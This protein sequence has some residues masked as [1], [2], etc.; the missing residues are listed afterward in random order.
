MQTTNGQPL[1]ID[2]DENGSVTATCNAARLDLRSGYNEDWLQTLLFKEP[3]LLSVGMVDQRVQKELIPLAMEVGLPSGICD[4]LFVSRDGYIAVVETKLWR[5]PQ[6][7]REVVAQT[8]DYATHIRR[9]D[10]PTL[11]SLWRERN[12]EAGTSL[13]QHVE[14]AET[15]AEW[16]DLVSRNLKAGRM[17]LV[18]AGDGIR[19]EAWDL[20]E[21]VSG[22]PDFEFRLG[23][24]EIRLYRTPS[25][26]V[27][28]VPHVQT[29]TK[30]VTR[31]IVRIE[32]EH[33]LPEGIRVQVET[34][35]DKPRDAGG[36]GRTTPKPEDLPLE[37]FWD[38][39]ASESGARAEEVRSCVKRLLADLDDE[40][41][42]MRMKGRS[43]IF[44]APIGDAEAQV[45]RLYSNGHFVCYVTKGTARDIAR[46]GTEAD[47]M[48][49]RCEELREELGINE[50][51][52][53]DIGLRLSSRNYGK[54]LAWLR[55]SKAILED[56]TLEG[57]EAHGQGT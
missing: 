44:V 11:E 45:G 28:A 52:G 8:L 57:S 41:F 46:D 9:W 43:P 42:G 32:G 25:G 50:G 34:T 7:R 35:P 4:A 56:T 48:L 33:R 49:R 2:C 5:N 20:A 54:I 55:R 23:L 22:H 1:V 27:I 16:T 38:Y 40:E 14:P 24:V 26:T 53:V 37:E 3:A 13:W 36:S 39:V 17:T 6:S 31:A 21:T 51:T 19:E 10:Y 15:E 30:E 47:H 12:P 29:R 18:V